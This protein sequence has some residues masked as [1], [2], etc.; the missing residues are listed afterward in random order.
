MKP[1]SMKP[2]SMKLGSIRTIS[3]TWDG[4]TARTAAKSLRASAVRSATTRS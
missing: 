3:G 2:G 4:R 1:G